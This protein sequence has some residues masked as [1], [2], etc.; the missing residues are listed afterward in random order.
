MEENPSQDM[1]V[2]R[3]KLAILPLDVLCY[4]LVSHSGGN[5]VTGQSHKKKPEG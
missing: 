1:P 2:Q 5:V 4:E 3:L